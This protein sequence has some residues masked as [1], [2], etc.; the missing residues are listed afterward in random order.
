MAREAEVYAG[1]AVAGATSPEPT[2]AMVQGACIAG[3]L[4]LAWSCG[5]IV[6]SHDAFFADPVARM[7]I[8]GVEYFAHPWW[9]PPRFAEE[10]LFLGERVGAKRAREHGMVNRVVPRDR[11]EAAARCSS[12]A[13][14]AARIR[15][16]GRAVMR[17]RTF[18]LLA[19]A[20]MLLE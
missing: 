6:A 9:M 15:L 20:S 2:I 16:S 17:N 4:M 5:L 11:L 7:G 18:Q 13:S 14:I 3:G 12:M 8:R 10:F 1:C 19:V